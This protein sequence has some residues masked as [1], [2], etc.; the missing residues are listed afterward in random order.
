MS[1]LLFAWRQVQTFL[2]T[3]GIVLWAIVGLSLVL[4]TLVLERYWFYRRVY[5]G[6][7]RGWVERWR[8]RADKA[9]WRAQRI[10]EGM[11]A[12]AR[13]QLGYTLPLI[14]TLVA[15]CPLF[16]LLGTVTGMIQVFDVLAVTGTGSPRAMASGVARATLPTMAGMVVAIAGLY[17]S[18]RLQH[19]SRMRVQYLRDELGVVEGEA[20]DAPA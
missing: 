11:V 3:G 12:E 5:P 6:R 15:L 2:D 19:A 9:S 8:L 17:F 4:W 7:V 18:T 13:R 1:E 10:R 20:S 14:K 16:G